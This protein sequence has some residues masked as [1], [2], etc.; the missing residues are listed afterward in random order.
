[1]VTMIYSAPL[2][3]KSHLPLDKATISS[4]DE[5]RL[6]RAVYA[7]YLRP[8][9][10]APQ[11]GVPVCD[12]QL[13]SYS[14]RNLELFADTAMRAA[15]YLNL[16]AKGPVPL[17]RITERWT[18][19]R[20]NF[21]FKK[22]Q[23]NFER[24][25]VRRLIQIQ[26]GEPEVVRAWLGFLEK[27]QYHG[28]GMKANVWEWEELGCGKKMEEEAKAAAEETNGLWEGFGRRKLG[29]EEKVRELLNSEPFRRAMHGDA[30]MILPEKEGRGQEYKTPLHEVGRG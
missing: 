15:Y 17:P 12:L 27:H 11:Y 6:P 4:L 25:T 14:V 23:E 19:P 30:P 8:L 22:S 26:D 10:R 7:A 21:I 29:P 5:L 1:M 9:R 20:A 3:A 2:D 28:V 13:R 18:V 16:P 24:R